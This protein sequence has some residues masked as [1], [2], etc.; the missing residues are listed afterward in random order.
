MSMQYEMLKAI[1]KKLENLK[2]LKAR[3]KIE[4]VEKEIKNL[5]SFFEQ[6][7]NKKASC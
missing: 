6:C 3:G 2:K 5:K 7:T 1:E 4:K